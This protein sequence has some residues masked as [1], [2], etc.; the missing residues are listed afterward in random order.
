MHKNACAVIPDSIPMGQ[1]RAKEDCSQRPED[2]VSVRGGFW[3]KLGA[4]SSLKS[5]GKK[6]KRRNRYGRVIAKVARA[7][8]HALG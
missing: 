5:A 7:Q 3:S 2:L 1:L 4:N 8:D 6:F